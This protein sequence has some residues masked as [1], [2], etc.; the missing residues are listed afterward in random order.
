MNLG[1]QGQSI[2]SEDFGYTVSLNLS[3]GYE[4]RIETDFS[5]HDS[6][7]DFRL[8]PGVDPDAGALRL[9]ALTGNV[10][11]ESRAESSGTLRLGFADGARL[12]VEPDHNFEAWT[13]AG[14][15]GMKVACMP[16]GE[17]AVWS[18][19]AKEQERG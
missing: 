10:V 11:T 3:G 12:R 14:P 4:I 9:R 5:L 7:G 18:P 8:S 1:F 16:G 6:E 15:N 17:L 19:A 2:I 13:I